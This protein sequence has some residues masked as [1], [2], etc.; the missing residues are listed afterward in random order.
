MG[1][2]ADSLVYRALVASGGR[3]GGGGGGGE[4]PDPPDDGKT[5]LYINIPDNAVAGRQPARNQVPLYI[6][7][8]IDKGVIVDWGDGSHT[9]TLSGTDRV[10]TTHTYHESGNF[11]I[12][13]TP[14]DEC[15]LGIGNRAVTASVMGDPS[16]SGQT[17]CNMLRHVVVGAHA[18]LTSY[19]FRKCQSLRSVRVPSNTSADA[20]RA[21]DGCYSLSKLD[22]PDGVKLSK[23]KPRSFYE[24]SSLSN[25]VIAE[26]VTEIGE[27]SFF[28]CASLTSI[29]IPPGVVSIG[30]LAFSGCKGIA[31]YHVL[32]TTPPAL[33]SSDVFNGMSSDCVIYV[34]RG[35]LDAYQTATNW[36]KYADKMREGTQ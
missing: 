5:R 18:G 32:A 16:D 31:E 28:G 23:S 2:I 30:S 4:Y 26:S 12:T 8:T 33:A 36:S 3:S 10:N 17:Y 15:T 21:F 14:V 34:P 35:C 22:V 13:L 9:E 6:T 24:C 7:Q 11:V 19:A 29:V 1:N 27:S 20:S 25:V